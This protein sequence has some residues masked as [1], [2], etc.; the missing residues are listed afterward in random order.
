MLESLG[1]PGVRMTFFPT[2]SVH[3]PCASGKVM[4]LISVGW[5]CSGCGLLDGV[6]TSQWP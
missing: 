4:S 1:G 6:K 3:T 5:R 2:H